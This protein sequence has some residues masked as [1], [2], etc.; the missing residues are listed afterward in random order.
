[1]TGTT[2]NSPS[3]LDSQEPGHDS[4]AAQDAD[5]PITAVAPADAVTEEAIATWA[6]GVRASFGRNRQDYNFAVCDALAA[7]GISPTG[8]NL[9]RVG[10]W[11]T[12][13]SVLADVQSWYQTL[14]TRL[15]DLESSVPLPARRQANILLEQLFSIA[16]EASR[17]KL[18]EAL[19]PLHEKVESLVQARL[20]LEDANTELT[21]RKDALGREVEH[22]Q[23]ELDDSRQSVSKLQAT[24]DTLSSQAAAA[25]DK[26]AATEAELRGA[27]ADLRQELA[28]KDAAH[29]RELLEHT[30]RADA[31]RKRQL[32]AM[33]SERTDFNHRLAAAQQ[34]TAGLRANLESVRQELGRASVTAATAQTAHQGA[35]A[36]L[37]AERGRWSERELHFVS[38]EYRMAALLRLL[39]R[40]K[41]V[42]I[43][44][45]LDGA[46]RT[47]PALWLSTELGI[48]PGSAEA[49]L[50][51]LP[52]QRDPVNKK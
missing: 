7:A 6:S 31:E 22:L 47:E 11:G 44:V 10:K 14:A 45:T 52:S 17:L 49:I 26:A 19:Q 29:A 48:S 36:L 46:N 50:H 42:G 38:D 41:Q 25:R 35:Q 8:R 4:D 40:G 28:A 24:L 27:N 43:K 39:Q 30:T 2:L 51:G 33:D 32:L 9:L 15:R 3:S 20:V 12:N 18:E 13:A 37:E 23:H 16:Q 34:E 5:Q 1:M 21:A